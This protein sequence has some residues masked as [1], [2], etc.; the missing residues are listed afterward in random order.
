MAY[1][2]QSDYEQ[3][4][5]REELRQ[6]TDRRNLGQIDTDVLG[7]AIADADA[8]ID[9]Y[10]SVR[11][12]T[13]LSPVPA[14]ITRLACD[15]VRY[16]LF[17]DRVTEAVRMRRDDAIGVLKQ[18][19]SGQLDIGATGDGAQSAGAPQFTKDADDRLFTHTTLDDF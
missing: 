19:R 14:L 5:G 2:T 11:Y 9:S 1:S 13:P 3:R 7:R 4:Y 10:L 16:N 8:E 18:I 12:T 15:L 17:E 6:L